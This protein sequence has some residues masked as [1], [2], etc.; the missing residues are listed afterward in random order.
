[1]TLNYNINN[2]ILLKLLKVKLFATISHL[3]TLLITFSIKFKN[4][5]MLK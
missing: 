1:M 2:I 3:I 4:P 5:W